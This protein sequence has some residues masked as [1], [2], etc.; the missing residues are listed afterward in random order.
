LTDAYNSQNR[1]HLNYRRFLEMV[2]A[3]QV[4]TAI[5][6]YSGSKCLMFNRA[7]IERQLQVYAAKA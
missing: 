4:V 3:L 1:L 6:N 7:E 2:G 5:K